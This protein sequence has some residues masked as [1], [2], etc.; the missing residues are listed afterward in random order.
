MFSNREWDMHKELFLA[1]FLIFVRNNCVPS[2]FQ[3]FLKSMDFFDGV[4][5]IMSNNYHWTNT[6]FQSIKWSDYQKSC[7]RFPA[8]N[9]TM[10]YKFLLQWL[11]LTSKNNFGNQLYLYCLCTNSQIE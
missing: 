3:E 5:S 8:H 11:P 10:V 6:D 4:K 9:Y 1:S 7:L 2:Y